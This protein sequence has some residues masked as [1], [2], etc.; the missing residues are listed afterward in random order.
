[1]E[2]CHPCQ[3]QRRT[4]ELPQRSTR[5]VFAGASCSGHLG[6][7]TV[8]ELSYGT[9]G[10]THT[11]L[12]Y[13]FCSLGQDKHCPDGA[14]LTT[15]V[16]LRT[17]NLYGVTYS[18]STPND[19]TVYELSPVSGGWNET[20]IHNFT[21]MIDGYIPDGPVSF[22]PT[23][24]LFGTVSGG[25]A[26]GLGGVFRL[27]TKGAYREIP[28][29]TGDG[30]QSGVL[31]DTKRGVLYGT[32]LGGGNDFYDGTGV[33]F[34]VSAS[35]QATTIYAFCSQVNCTDGSERVQR[36]LKMN[37]EISTVRQLSAAQR[38]DMAASMGV[39]AS[40][41]KSSRN[42]GLGQYVEITAPSQR[43][44]ESLR[45]AGGYVARSAVC[46]PFPSGAPGRIQS[47]A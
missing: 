41:T 3:V 28:P 6:A 1:V 42:W 30:P 44:A 46:L 14:Y 11:V 37:H 26:N 4:E 12:Y 19:G 34:Q 39:A 24:D 33:V 25:G 43:V 21:S 5:R 38:S 45:S 7:G 32:T 13:S 2:V 40:C 22:D 8:F 15:G 18:G 10:W 16:T 17:G 35:G 47:L 29:A 27:T 31:I 20:V 23:G 36:W 9:N